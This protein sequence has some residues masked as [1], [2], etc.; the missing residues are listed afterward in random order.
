MLDG[1]IN[2]F[3]D[4][5]M[6][7]LAVLFILY[8]MYKKSL[9]FPDCGGNITTI[10]SVEEWTSLFK[11]AKGSKKLVFV[12]F[13]ATW[14]PPCKTAAPVF[15]R[16]SEQYGGVVFAKV[17]VDEASEVS[18]QNGIRAMPT[19]KLFDCEGALKGEQQGFVESKLTFLLNDNGAQLTPPTPSKDD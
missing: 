19:F 4:N 1:L 3:T 5:P 17:N 2:Y 14:C 15:A 18:K 12:D 11:H 13:Y 8:N 9:P 16:L 6:L 7:V 10:H